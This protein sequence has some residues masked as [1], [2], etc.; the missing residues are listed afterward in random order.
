MK[1]I[2]TALGGSDLV[3]ADGLGG[4]SYTEFLEDFVVHLAGHHRGVGLTAVE[5]GQA[6]EGAATVVVEEAQDGER[7]KHLIG[8]QARVAA[9]EHRHLGVLDGLYHLL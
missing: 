4:E 6:V 5:E 1:T 3:L 2:A 8:V 7:H 9:V